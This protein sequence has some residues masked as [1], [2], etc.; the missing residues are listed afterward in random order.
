MAE[1][2]RATPAGVRALEAGRV[3]AGACPLAS[4]DKAIPII[5]NFTTVRNV[6][7]ERSIEPSVRAAPS[8]RGPYGVGWKKLLP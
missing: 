6:V 3:A 7:V 1:S 2:I 5:S 4:M 8:M